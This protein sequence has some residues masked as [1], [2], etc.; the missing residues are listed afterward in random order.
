MNM[1]YIPKEIAIVTHKT[2]TVNVGSHWDVKLKAH[3]TELVV[4]GLIS[5]AS[6]KEAIENNKKD[7]SWRDRSVQPSVEIRKNIPIK[8]VKVCSTGWGKSG[9]VYN[10]IVD[11]IYATCREDLIMNSIINEGVEKGGILK[12]EFIWAKIG[13][14]MDLVRVGSAVHASMVESTR[15]RDL[16]K[17]KMKD[18]IPGNI[19]MS[20]QGDKYL[21]L[22]RVKTHELKIKYNYNPYNI[23]YN[24]DELSTGILLINI[25]DNADLTIDK[26]QIS[27][28]H[29][30][31]ECVGSADTTGIFEKVRSLA[32]EKIGEFAVRLGNE[33][34]NKYN[35]TSAA[36]SF[37]YRCSSVLGFV[38][39]FPRKGKPVEKFDY[40]MVVT[41][42]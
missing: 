38:N 34:N 23:I 41:L 10:V 8:N 33:T 1:G 11:G 31:V 7:I 28:T 5:E 42:I 29:S 25:D 15:R 30:L 40:D 14:T 27:K 21:F 13:K 19:Y 4:Q 17:L 18:L 2:V 32:M 9:P 24:Y 35:S 6:N 26:C 36:D 39:M 3:T 12:G 22:D 20:R 16:P 37:Y